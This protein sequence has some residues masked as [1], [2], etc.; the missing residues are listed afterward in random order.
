MVKILIVDDDED[1][2]D[3]LA[4]LAELQGHSYSIAHDGRSAIKLSKH[5]KFDVVFLDVKMPGIDGIETLHRLREAQAD[6]KI[7]MVTGYATTEQLDAAVAAGAFTVLE[8]PCPVEQVLEIVERAGCEQIVLI[9]DNDPDY[10]EMLED[11]LSSPGRSVCVANNGTDAI[12]MLERDW[13][14]ILLLDPRMPGVS[15]Y[16]VLEALKKRKLT[17]P[18]IVLTAYSYLEEDLKP[19]RGV[20]KAVLPKP[21]VPLRLVE[22]VASYGLSGDARRGR[23]CAFKAGKV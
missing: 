6:L 11:A 10:S 18:V 4:D 2:A 15:G 20:I 12:A 5:E 13:V 14:S 8:K 22:A 21:V 9:A 1:F 17:V 7:V 23:P 16:D 3:S 19:Y